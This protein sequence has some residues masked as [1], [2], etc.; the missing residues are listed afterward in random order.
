M[1]QA[2]RAETESISSAKFN[3]AK[4]L[5]GAMGGAFAGVKTEEDLVRAKLF[6]KGLQFEAPGMSEIIDDL[7][8]EDVHA[9]NNFLREQEQVMD[10]VFGREQLGVRKHELGIR[11]DELAFQR[12]RLGKPAVPTT[13][14][15]DFQSFYAPWLA[16]KGLK[17]SP[18]NEIKARN[19][20]KKLGREPSDFDKRL[21]LFRSDPATY[22]ALYRGADKATR[23]DQELELFRNDPQEFYKFMKRDPAAAAE[24]LTTTDLGE[25][26]PE[27]TLWHRVGWFSTGPLSGIPRTFGRFTGTGDYSIATIQAFKNSKNTLITALQ[28]NPRY[29]VSEANRL[30]E[31]I[32][33]QPNFFDAVGT[34]QTKMREVDRHLSQVE[35]RRAANGDQRSVLAI[36]QFRRQMGVPAEAE[37]QDF[38]PPGVASQG[39]WKVRRVSPPPQ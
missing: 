15:R 38:D 1:R 21:G 18:T 24:M 4:Q 13:T 16:D 6:V 30:A 11:K 32:D 23:F 26:S 37:N 12:E 14:E 22:K 31:E 19:E 7:P 27:D 39:R 33:I 25:V 9:F 5:M 36:K 3:K 34:I 2:E 35:K 20:F 29:A 28:E 10:E 8:L 17:K